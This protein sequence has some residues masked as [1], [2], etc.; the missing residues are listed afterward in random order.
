MSAHEEAA[1]LASKANPVWEVPKQ[2]ATNLKSRSSNVSAPP[3]ISAGPGMRRKPSNASARERTSP[4]ISNQNFKSR[5]AVTSRSNPDG[6]GINNGRASTPGSEA[7]SHMSGSAAMSLPAPDTA[8]SD[9]LMS[10]AASRISVPVSAMTDDSL[11]LRENLAPIT[12]EV[13]SAVS[14]APDSKNFIG[15]STA[16]VSKRTR[17]TSQD[18]KSQL[19]YIM[20]KQS[21]AKPV[22][23]SVNTTANS[24]Y[25]RNNGTGGAGYHR[26][27]PSL[28][29]S[30]VSN[31]SSTALT[32]REKR[33]L[34]GT[35]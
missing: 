5:S 9:V 11:A 27:T 8:Y 15:A 3:P 26:P 20:T 30:A 35:K 25:G 1:N 33:A 24:N 6:F 34:M 32:A 12:R 19:D 16:M 2:K 28:T 22:Q 29:G 4:S 23:N 13:F 31:N 10:A 21:K 17:G 14:P 7:D 18:T